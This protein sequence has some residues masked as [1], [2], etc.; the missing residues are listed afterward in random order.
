MQSRREKRGMATLRS[1][2]RADSTAFPI[3]HV[4]VLD[5]ACV[6]VRSPP[7]RRSDRAARWATPMFSVLADVGVESCCAV[8]ERVNHSLGSIRTAT[9]WGHGFHDIGGLMAPV[10]PRYSA[11][12]PA[13]PG[14]RRDHSPTRAHEASEMSRV[15]A[16]CSWLSSFRAPYVPHLRRTPSVPPAHH[17]G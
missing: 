12:R 13:L 5:V 14:R 8:S 11:L 17:G 3:S 2:R 6:D 15:G 10:M 1:R 9:G 7:L 16:C 4:A